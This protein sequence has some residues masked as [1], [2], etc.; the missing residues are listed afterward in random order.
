MENKESGVPDESNEELGGQIRVFGNL[1]EEDSYEYETKKEPPRTEKGSE[2]RNSEKETIKSREQKGNMIDLDAQPHTPG[3]Y[4]IDEKMQV[5]GRARGMFEW[6]PASVKFVNTQSQAEFENEPVL[7][8]TVLDWLL[9]HQDEIPEE[10]KGKIIPFW[11][12]LYTNEST[13]FNYYRVLYWNEGYG[14]Q[15]HWYQE[16]SVAGRAITDN[17]IE[18]N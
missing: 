16:G 15:D 5:Q 18:K 9:Q 7:P 1:H 14:W 6:D 10:W 8:A 2:L 11:G 4:K 12:T 17:V 3:G 13:G